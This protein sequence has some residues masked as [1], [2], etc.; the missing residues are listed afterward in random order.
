M[1]RQRRDSAAAKQR[2]DNVDSKRDLLDCENF[3]F[4]K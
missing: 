3:H 1:S 4:E 2:K